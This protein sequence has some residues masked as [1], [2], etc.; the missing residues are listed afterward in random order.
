MIEK[1]NKEI[2]WIKLLKVVQ[3]RDFLKKKKYLIILNLLK[4]RIQLLNNGKIIHHKTKGSVGKAHVFTL[5]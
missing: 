5:K 4:D 1:K 2:C 3:N